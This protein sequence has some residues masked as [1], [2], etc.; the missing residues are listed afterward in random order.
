MKA[1]KLLGVSVVAVAL[2]ASAAFAKV[3]SET[4]A[5]DTAAE[6]GHAG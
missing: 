5:R 2:S 3:G 6:G 4:G 1:I